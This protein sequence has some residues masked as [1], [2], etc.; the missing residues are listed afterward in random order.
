MRIHANA[1]L[2]PSGRR[3]LI[4]RIE[5]DGWTVQAAAQAAGISERTARKWRG[6][7]RAEG[8]LGLRDRS[9][10]PKTVANRTDEARIACIAALRRLRMTGP[11][12]AET[13]QMAIS[14]VSGILTS[15]NMG[16]LGR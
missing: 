5:R 2:S 9:S 14:T 3:L 7:W 11:E 6:R 10:A 12:I 13:L 4:D 16:K 1:R 8:E 15:I